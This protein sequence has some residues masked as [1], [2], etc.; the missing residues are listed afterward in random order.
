MARMLLIRTRK[1]LYLLCSVG[2]VAGLLALGGTANAAPLPT[3]GQATVAAADA[4]DAVDEAQDN[5]ADKTETST[6]TTSALTT[7]TAEL[8][9]LLGLPLPLSL[10][11]DARKTLLSITLVP[12]ATT[13]NISATTATAAAQTALNTAKVALAAALDTKAKA[14][15]P[16]ADDENCPDFA[17]QAVAQAHLLADK[18]D[19]DKLDLDKDG[20]ACEEFFAVPAATTTLKAPIPTTAVV[21]VTN[22]QFRTIPVTSRGV[23]T[24]GA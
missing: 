22:P 23:A 12:N 9:G 13:A 4:Q 15:A 6:S 17:S 10:V 18:T 24:G 21:V 3:C 5:L 14:C 2:M 20:L 1:V 19:P 8:N 7:L 16:P 11:D